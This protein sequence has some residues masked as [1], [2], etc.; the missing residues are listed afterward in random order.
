VTNLDK[1]LLPARTGEDAVT[2]RD[3]LRYA[4]AN[5]GAQQWRAWTSQVDRPHQ[6]TY[7]LIDLDPG[8]A[9]TWDIRSPP[10]G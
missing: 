7:A 6:P 10:P 9:T 5:F 4:T 2:K 8:G 3:L 1:V